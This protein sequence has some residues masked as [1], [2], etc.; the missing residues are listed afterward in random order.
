LASS[1]G[2]DASFGGGKHLDLTHECTLELFAF[3]RPSS[4]L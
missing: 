2:L 4:R 1:W 3:G